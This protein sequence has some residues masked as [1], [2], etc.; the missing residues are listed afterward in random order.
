MMLMQSK[1]VLID[2]FFMLILVSMLELMGKP[3]RRR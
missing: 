2:L 1:Q 3:L